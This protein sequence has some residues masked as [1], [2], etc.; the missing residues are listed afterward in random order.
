MLLIIIQTT[1]YDLIIITKKCQKIGKSGIFFKKISS[2]AG[3]GDKQVRLKI[4]NSCV[5]QESEEFK[6]KCN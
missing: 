2:F 1:K 5:E 6:K 4:V 3:K